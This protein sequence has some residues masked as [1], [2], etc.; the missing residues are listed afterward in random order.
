MV[1]DFANR[2][3]V[4]VERD[5]GVYYNEPNTWS[6]VWEWDADVTFERETSIFKECDSWILL[7]MRSWRKKVIFMKIKQPNKDGKM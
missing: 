2:E 5:M 6:Y 7:A 1:E 3:N 4:V